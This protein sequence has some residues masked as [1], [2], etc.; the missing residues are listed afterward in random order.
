M[1]KS[2]ALE[3]YTHSVVMSEGLSQGVDGYVVAGAKLLTASNVELDKLGRAS[4][5]LGFSE[6]TVTEYAAQAPYAA[7]GIAPLRLS[8]MENELVA[9]TGTRC[10]A[11]SP[12][13]DAWTFKGEAGSYRTQKFASLQEANMQMK[14]ADSVVA[15]GK[16][17][18]CFG[19]Q[20][21]GEGAGVIAYSNIYDEETGGA[22]YTWKQI[23]ATTA[24]GTNGG[25]RV[26]ACGT[27]DSHVWAIYTETGDTLY[28]AWIP[29]ATVSSAWT[30][31]ALAT[32]VPAVFDAVS[33]GAAGFIVCFYD[34]ISGVFRIKTFNT[35]GTELAA[36]T[37]AVGSGPPPYSVALDWDGTSVH[38]AYRDGPDLKYV[39]YTSVTTTYTLDQSGT[40]KTTL[41]GTSYNVRLGIGYHPQRDKCLVVWGESAT[42]GAF[43]SETVSTLNWREVD[44]TTGAVAGQ[45]QRQPYCHLCSRPVVDNGQYLFLIAGELWNNNIIPEGV[46]D[47]PCTGVFMMRVEPTVVATLASGGLTVT[48]FALGSGFGMFNNTC[49][50]NLT[51]SSQ[52]GWY[53]VQGIVGITGVNKT[54]SNFDRQLN[55]Y[56]FDRDALG[57]HRVLVGGSG[58]LVLGG[59]PAAYDGV[60]VYNVGSMERPTV[61][62]TT[63][64]TGGSLTS[65]SDYGVRLVEEWVDGKG[66]V[67]YGESSFPVSVTLGASD[68]R[69]TLAVR[70]TQL[71]NKREWFP[72]TV[73]YGQRRL[74]VYRTEANGEVYY[75]DGFIR[76]NRYATDWYNYN[77]DTA[78]TTVRTQ[79]QAYTTGGEL[80]NTGLPSCH[81][82]CSVGRRFFV[83]SDEDPRRVYYSKPLTAGR[84]IEFDVNFS[85]LDFPEDIVGM[86]ALDG[87]PVLLSATGAYFV[88]GVGPGSTGQ[89]GDAFA[90]RSVSG[91]VGCAD[92]ES[93]VGIPE[94][95]M[96]RSEQG[97]YL[98]TR[99][100]EYQYIG[101]G[102]EDTAALYP[103]TLEVVVDEELS[104]VRWLVQASGGSTVL[105]CFNWATGQWYTQTPVVDGYLRT[106]CMHGG[107]QWS[108]S[109]NG[110]TY[111][112][113]GWLDTEG[114]Y[115]ATIRFG[116]E[117]LGE[118][119][120]RKR[121][122]DVYL[123]LRRK[124]V[125]GLR[126]KLYYNRLD[127]DV[128]TY[129]VDQADV[130]SMGEMEQFRAQVAHGRGAS[131]VI[132]VEISDVGVEVEPGSYSDSES[133]QFVGLTYV[134]GVEPGAVQ[135][136]NERTM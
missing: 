5:R 128:D 112:S 117:N 44:C 15:A 40:V 39:S 125:H 129:N 56:R 121:W 107:E 101:G 10:Y 47:A 50:R 16:V 38:I 58:A 111:K 79:V 100:G 48:S 18:V 96:F 110:K 57:K 21:S 67:V 131:D 89:P 127:T 17:F 32:Q 73:T 80:S 106:I 59:V 30:S 92:Q 54:G 69:I 99:S 70:P 118:L 93:V 46:A 35:T 86:G 65:S 74:A 12:Q 25:F 62:E 34:D 1:A 66:R 7:A 98:I 75:L 115:S 45:E 102:I 24:A 49:V 133:W 116:W 43:T 22:I 27:N 26:L 72:T 8:S 3:R 95:V 63:A 87:V 76:L 29:T 55:V 109:T 64:T 90:V 2:R 94:G 41:G 114:T 33:I 130:T 6:Q 53:T 108:A 120:S 37:F 135:L 52:G 82:G 103:T 68:T 136:R 20:D 124:A 14:N 61:L 113:T 85:Y 19:G 77:I 126:C 11:Y 31:V 97:F 105:L 91:P 122:W 4:R 28:G 119:Q 71:E 13:L 51:E 132:S 84:A 36:T 60:S 42:S 78:D 134:V 9:Y 81:V 123:L 23:Q 104:V 88:D 83:R